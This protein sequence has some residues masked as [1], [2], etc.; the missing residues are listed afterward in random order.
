[1]PLPVARETLLGRLQ[2]TDA[3]VHALGHVVVRHTLGPGNEEQL[4]LQLADLVGSPADDGR[5]AALALDA[6]CEASLFRGPLV[7]A[8]DLDEVGAAEAAGLVLLEAHVRAGK[9]AVLGGQGGEEIPGGGLGVQ[10]LGLGFALL[11]RHALFL[12]FLAELHLLTLLGRGK[13]PAERRRLRLAD[14]SR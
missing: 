10:L 11:A 6:R 1:M 3:R 8:S 5:V 7:E 9:A 12:F 4:E 13:H 14:L 2:L